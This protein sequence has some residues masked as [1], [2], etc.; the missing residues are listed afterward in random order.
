MGGQKFQFAPKFPKNGRLPALKQP[1]MSQSCAKV[2]LHDKRESCAKVVLRNI[3]IFW[4]DYF[5]TI[6]DKALKS[7]QK[8]NF[9]RNKK[10][11]LIY[12]KS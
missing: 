3:A 4:W 7:M 6:G 5:S 2:A 10:S 9:E 12:H 8:K 11:Y 1:K